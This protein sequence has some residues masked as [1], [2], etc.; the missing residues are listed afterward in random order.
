[1]GVKREK[2]DIPAKIIKGLRDCFEICAEMEA[3]GISF[4]IPFLLLLLFVFL[5][6]LS[7]MSQCLSDH[8]GI[9]HV[10]DPMMIKNRK[11]SRIGVRA[12]G[13][14][15]ACENESPDAVSLAGDDHRLCDQGGGWK[16]SEMINT[17]AL[18]YASSSIISSAFT[19]AGCKSVPP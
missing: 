18:R 14:M 19:I 15:K 1:M 2:C 10:I 6:Q 12:T 8:L 11:R 5:F 7:K 16:K 9:V 3:Y 13:N 4:R 17:S